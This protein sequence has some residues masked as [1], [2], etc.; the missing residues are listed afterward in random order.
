MP[1]AGYLYS[2][3]S[4][5]QV[6]S[7]IEW[8]PTVV[9]LAPNHTG[10]GNAFASAWSK[11]AFE[12]PLGAVPVAEEFIAR[13]EERSDLV[14]D[15]R[16]AHLKEHAVEVELPF[17]AHLAPHVS[18]VPI[19]ISDVDWE[20][21]RQLAMDLTSV[22]QCWPEDVTLLA[23]S[24]MTHFQSAQEAQRRDT[25]A[26]ECI[27]RLDGKRL[28]ETCRRE[29]ISMCGRAPAAVVLEASKA[30]GATRAEVVDYRNS[31]EV[32]GDEDSVVAYAGI[33]IR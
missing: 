32:T 12:T 28:L 5:A 30:L 6:F 7:R 24:D 33:V 11:G 2:G 4:A 17:L 18:I 22:I 23:S 1:H 21:C 20:S 15:D 14:R 25:M 29:S 3:T 13:L 27:E 9:L 19:I 26:L 10:L 16:V 8:T 31:A